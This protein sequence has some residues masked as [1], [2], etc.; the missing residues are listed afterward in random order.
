LPAHGERKGENY[1]CD[2]WN[3]ISNLHKILTCGEILDILKASM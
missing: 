3:G 1:R 2:I